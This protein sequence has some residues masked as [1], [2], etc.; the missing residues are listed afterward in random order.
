[1]GQPNVD[2]E[3]LADVLG[4]MVERVGYLGCVFDDGRV[5]SKRAFGR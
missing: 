3:A 2:G 5:P 1:V 4:S